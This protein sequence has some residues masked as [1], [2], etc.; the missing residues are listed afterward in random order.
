[1]HTDEYEISIARELNHHQ[2]V[3]KKIKTALAE[4]RQQFGMDY[5]EAAKAAIEGKL[6]ITAKELAR[7]QDDVEALPVWEQR[8]EEYRKALA[9][10]RISA[11]RF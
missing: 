3:V 7:W 6:T 9:M 11:S 4:R 2:Q 5:P 8:L 1:M 10:M